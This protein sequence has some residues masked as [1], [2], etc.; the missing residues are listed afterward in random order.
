MKLNLFDSHVHTSHSFDADSSLDELSR[1]ALEKG[2]MGFAVTDHFDCGM[3]EGADA[4]GV[5]ASLREIWSV[6]RREFPHMWEGVRGL[7]AAA[8]R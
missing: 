1:A 7:L 5:R 3:E 6:I 4:G 2:V 8:L